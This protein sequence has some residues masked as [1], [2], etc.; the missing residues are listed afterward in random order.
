MQRRDKF[1]LIELLVVIAIIAILAAILLPALN[2]ARERAKAVNCVSNLKQV[3][4]ACLAYSNESGGL[5]PNNNN[6]SSDK[7]QWLQVL[8]KSGFCTDTRGTSCPQ[9]AP[10][11]KISLTSEGFNNN[12]ATYGLNIGPYANGGSINLKGMPAKPF[13]GPWHGSIAKQ[14]PSSFPVA[15]DSVQ[16]T[17]TTNTTFVAQNH[18]FYYPTYNLSGSAANGRAHTRHLSRCNAAAADGH[19]ETLSRDGLIQKMGFKTDGIL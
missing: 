11:G 14:S 13:T 3:I 8:V 4:S 17:S 16:F 18:Y 7:M 1:T 19:V 5:L 10:Y 2:K 6:A 12:Y 9:V 15:V